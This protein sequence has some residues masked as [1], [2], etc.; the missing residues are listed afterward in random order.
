[1]KKI[2]AIVAVLVVYWLMN[3]ATSKPGIPF[4]CEGPISYYLSKDSISRPY[5]TFAQNDSIFIRSYKDSLWDKK[6]NDICQILRDS[7][8]RK[9]YNI[10]I[11]DSTSDANL[12]NT[13]YGRMIHSKKC[14]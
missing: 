1:M 14:P 3:I 8:T 10:I 5:Y 2:I 4:V 6:L 7:C 12:Y 11:L 13:P 9:A